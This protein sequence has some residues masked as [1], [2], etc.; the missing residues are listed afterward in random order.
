[1]NVRTQFN[2]EDQYAGMLKKWPDKLLQ[3]IVEL[4]YS[5]FKGNLNY[6]PSFIRKF[7]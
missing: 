7:Y 6:N 5:G 4:Y 1:M 3:K 2:F